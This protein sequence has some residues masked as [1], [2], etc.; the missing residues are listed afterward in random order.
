MFELFGKRLN[1]IAKD[2]EDIFIKLDNQNRSPTVASIGIYAKA[3]DALAK[4]VD[5]LYVT[6]QI[7]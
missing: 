4:K 3:N 5:E 7:C 1:Q 2:I 6:L